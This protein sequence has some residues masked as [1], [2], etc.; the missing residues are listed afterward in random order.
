MEE[1]I[2]S[3]TRQCI[4]YYVNVKDESSIPSIDC[5]IVES[6]LS[7]PLGQ[8]MRLRKI[9]VIMRFRIRS[10]SIVDYSHSQILTSNNHAEKLRRMLEKK[11]MI[12][13]EKATKQKEKEL[14][15]KKRVEEK[16]L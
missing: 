1:G 2:S 4:Y 12:E 16:V 13:E 5:T 15:K 10:E 8:F 9:Q 7:Q 6:N 11:E 14:T 3:P